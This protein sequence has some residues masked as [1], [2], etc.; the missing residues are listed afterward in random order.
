MKGGKMNEIKRIPT[1][2]KVISVLYYIGATILIISSIALI[3][4]GAVLGSISNQYPLLETL[5]II[6]G[7]LLIFIGILVIGLGILFFFIARGLWKG[8][9]WAKII[10]IVFSLLEIIFAIFSISGG[11]IAGGIINIIISLIIGGYLLLNNNVKT[12]FAS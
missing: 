1:G 9:S 6:G 5:G 7:G 10:V 11:D 2:V 3:I 8:K 4:G 12:A